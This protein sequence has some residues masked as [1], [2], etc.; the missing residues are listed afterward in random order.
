[1][2]K[3]A[4]GRL[5]LARDAQLPTVLG[6]AILTT[7]LATW[8]ALRPVDPANSAV[9]GFYVFVGRYE[10]LTT[11]LI[12]ALALLIG[13]ERTAEDAASEWL[14]PLT[15]R[16]D[17]RLTY[18]IACAAAAALVL[19]ALLACGI[20]VQLVLGVDLRGSASLIIGSALVRCYAAALL[21]GV[22]VLLIRSKALVLVL[23]TAWAMIPLAAL[24]SLLLTQ[25]SPVIPESL[26]ALLRWSPLALLFEGPSR[27]RVSAT[28]AVT[29]TAVAILIAPFT[30]ARKS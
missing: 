17:V 18:V 19:S 7:A 6:G 14:H 16:E 30:V 4:L 27:F 25:S 20:G 8:Y 12:A 22:L 11:W 3:V 29:L 13:I 26:R 23:L 1:M 21:G 5:L 2:S 10:L 9:G 28:F 15:A 24:F